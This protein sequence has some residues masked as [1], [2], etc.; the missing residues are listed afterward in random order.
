MIGRT[1]ARSPAAARI[2]L[3]VDNGW[4][5]APN[6]DA[7]Q[8]SD[9]RSRAARAPASAGRSPS[10]RPPTSPTS[11]CW[12]PARAERAA[13]ALA[14][15]PWLA[16][17]M[18]GDC[19]AGES[20]IRR[21]PQILWLCDGIDDGSARR[22]RATRLSRLG[23]LRIFAGTGNGPLALTCRRERRQRLRGRRCCAP[24]PAARAQGTVARY[25]RPRPDAR[26]AR[27]STST[28][29]RTER[30]GAHRTAAGN[31]QRDRA[32]RHRRRGQRGRRASVRSGAPRRAVGLV[33]ASNYERRA[34][35]AVRTSI[36]CER[37]LVALCRCAARARSRDLLSRSILGADPGRYRQDRR[38]R[39]RA[40]QQIRREWRRC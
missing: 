14:P 22:R 33:S 1:L 38:R 36:I 4:T 30:D 2:V 25:R 3:L 35:A 13:R 39:S 17:R 9:R 32:A 24:A 6:W 21:A 7:R 23:H 31:A 19:R 29:A 28:T 15:K 27:A 8:R 37:A 18:R 10:F 40:R 12:T 11:A 26:H 5:A 34:A 20:E 16:D